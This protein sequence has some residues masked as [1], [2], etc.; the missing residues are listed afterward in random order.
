[1]EHLDETAVDLDALTGLG[2]CRVPQVIGRDLPPG[3]DPGRAAAILLFENAW[4]NGTRL[5]YHL[6]DTP[7]RSRGSA[8]DQ[9]VVRRAFEAWEELGI[10]LSFLEVD[11]PAEAEVRI[12]FDHQD[13]SWSY[14]GRQ[15]LR[16]A[17]HERTMN[18]GW[19][20]H[21]WDHGFD[22]ALHEIGH[23]LALP[24]EHQ[25]PN[26]GIIWDEEAVYRAFAAAPNSWSRE[27]TFHNILRKLPAS[28]LRGSVWDRDSVMHYGF[29]AG[30][31]FEPEEFRTAPLKPGGGLSELD[32]EW[33]LAFYP[34]LEPAVPTLEPYVS[35]PLR[36][37]PGEQVERLIHPAHTGVH[38]VRTLGRADTVLVVVE[39]I[40]G[41]GSRFLA[42]DDDSGTG[43]N[44]EVEV[45]LFAGRT[46]RARLRLYWAGASGTT[47]LVLED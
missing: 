2:Y 17:Q 37:R 21:G 26:A 22:T 31:I 43:L 8:E 36:L 3:T 40:D 12:G 11:D 9:Q 13:G 28:I 23:T 10:G 46:Y 25:N 33:I 32:R 39:D 44:A 14:L 5:R 29:P 1:M 35:E 16:I 18:L 7:E 4:A 27:T 38:T 41:Q 15:V 20:L 47:A 24:H 19:R 6:L 30:L 45:K 34:S 42:G